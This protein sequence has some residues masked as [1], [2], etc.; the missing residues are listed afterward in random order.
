MVV[1]VFPEA[2]AVKKPNWHHDLSLV[3]F[4]CAYSTER[5]RVRTLN[6]AFLNPLRTIFTIYEEGNVLPYVLYIPGI[7]QSTLKVL[8]IEG[9]IVNEN[10]RTLA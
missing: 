6:A 1:A 10:T 3:L 5:I 7:R 8:D 9:F 4:L 2:Q